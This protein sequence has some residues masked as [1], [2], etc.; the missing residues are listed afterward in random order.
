M[1]K[2][3]HP[4]NSPWPRC[5][6]GPSR[7]LG[8]A[9]P[10]ASL[11][12]WALTLVTTWSGPGGWLTASA[13]ADPSKE[14]SAEVQRGDS[15]VAEEDPRRAPTYVV[16]PVA[17]YTPETSGTAA[18]VA[19]AFFPNEGDRPD[20]FNIA[21]AYTLRNQSLLT[22]GGQWRLSGGDWL[23][24]FSFEARRWSEDYFGL[25][26]DPG[27]RSERYLRRQVATR[28]GLRRRVLLP[29][30]YIGAFYDGALTDID[31]TP[32]LRRDDPLGSRGGLRSGG[33]VELIGDTRDSAIGPRSGFFFNLQA[34]GWHEA[35]GADFE[36]M[37]LT[38]D[39]RRYL[40]LR[41][42]HTLGLQLVLR[43]QLGEV[44]FYERVTVGGANL[45]RGIYENRFRGR[46]LWA[47]QAEY[48]SPTFW[49]RFSGVAFAGIGGVAPTRG[50]HRAALTRWAAGGGI[51]F[52]ANTE[53]NV[54]VRLDLGVTEDDVGVYFSLGEAF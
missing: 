24:G 27:L 53:Q 18:L 7:R 50:E 22:M 41:E 43:D 19:L 34:L 16:V 33:G 46:S 30:L 44:P 1:F 29:S 47:T 20:L 15:S 12:W 21:A 39:V 35:F 9:L 36:G 8:H 42:G 13:S 52:L 5:R 10:L 25:T 54:N 49:W 48:R 26:T 4:L 40:V 38:L 2:P 31:P 14:T 28:V 37:T 11:L 45:L 17:G 3:H 6:F 23:P 32:A 51:R